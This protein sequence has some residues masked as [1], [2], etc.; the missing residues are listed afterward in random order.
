MLALISGSVQRQQS[1][2]GKN[3]W[4]KILKLRNSVMV[5]VCVHEEDS[6]D[7]LI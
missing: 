4:E 6:Y 5:Y 3:I 7:S 1:F 2:S